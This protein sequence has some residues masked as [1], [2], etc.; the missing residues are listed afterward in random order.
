M[1]AR[2]ESP[3]PVCDAS[4]PCAYQGKAYNSDG[5]YIEIKVYQSEDGR[6]VATFRV[7]G[8]D[9]TMYV[10]SDDNEGKCHVNYNGKAYYFNI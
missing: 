5:G 2:A 3:A 9:H 10:I 4:K 6:W 1:P 7:G 8:V